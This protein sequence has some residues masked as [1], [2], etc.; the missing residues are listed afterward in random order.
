MGKK[1]YPWFMN[2]TSTWIC[3]VYLSYFFIIP[4][5]HPGISPLSE[6]N[7]VQLHNW[8]FSVSLYSDA[9][10][11]D[12]LIQPA[13]STYCDNPLTWMHTKFS[14]P[15]SAGRPGA[16]SVQGEHRDFP[17]R[18][19]F[20]WKVRG[21]CLSLCTSSQTCSP[22]TQGNQQQRSWISGVGLLLLSLPWWGQLLG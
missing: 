6:R 13:E 8:A 2:C 20:G 4:D 18:S 14:S 12:I 22:E 11:C 9:D 21:V 7:L 1:V 19:L 5:F 15:F 17:L 3:R 16:L 10:H